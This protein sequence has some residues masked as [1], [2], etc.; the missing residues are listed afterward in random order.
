MPKRMSS[1]NKSRGT[2]AKMVGGRV[3]VRRSVHTSSGIATYP[4]NHTYKRFIVTRRRVGPK[5]RR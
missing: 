2:I 1:R 5:R 3:K 4:H